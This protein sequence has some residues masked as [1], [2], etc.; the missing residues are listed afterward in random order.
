MQQS[1][2][3]SRIS[4]STAFATCLFIILFTTNALAASLRPTETRDL[5]AIIAP[6]VLLSPR[7]IFNIT[8]FFEGQ[9]GQNYV[10]C[11]EVY[12]CRAGYECLLGEKSGDYFCRDLSGDTT[13]APSAVPTS[14]SSSSKVPVG[15][16]VG[17]A[18]G[19]AAAIAIVCLLYLL[20][21][22]RR[23][24]A[25]PAIPQAPI[26]NLPNVIEAK[27][28][29]PHE[30]SYSGENWPP[31]SFLYHSRNRSVSTTSQSCV[32]PDGHTPLCDS[33]IKKYN[34]NISNDQ[35]VIMELPGTQPT[36]ELQGDDGYFAAK[37]FIP[38]PPTLDHA[39]AT[40]QSPS[41]A[42]SPMSP[43][44]RR[45]SVHYWKKSRGT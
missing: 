14:S 17:A 3:F 35:D 9:C 42:V 4:T 11:G 38:P 45:L 2:G 24:P 18:L 7:Q 27:Y 12:C 33:N 21:R 26:P 19:A 5:P 44:P 30:T 31:G 40:P 20:H 29:P 15:A 6:R 36:I 34:D 41:E 25:T 16:I 32:S 23:P 10:V 37:P 1:P 28:P 22:R 13:S 8:A 43:T 39:A